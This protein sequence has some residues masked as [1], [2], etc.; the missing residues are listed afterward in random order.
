MES[1]PGATRLKPRISWVLKSFS[2]MGQR[3][4][5]RTQPKQL[6][7]LQ[8]CPLPLHPGAHLDS[9]QPHHPQVCALT[10]CPPGPPQRW[11]GARRP[12][13]RYTG[14][15]RKHSPAETPSVQEHPRALESLKDCPPAPGNK[16]L[17]GAGDRNGTLPRA[18]ERSGAGALGT[19]S[20][21]W[22]ATAGGRI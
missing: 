13:S 22:G 5:A 19:A 18:W 21:A 9:T 8:S 1:F 2:L 14:E 15:W 20:Q 3:C 6:C 17:K 16:A 4:C 7:P 12:C 10:C 11:E